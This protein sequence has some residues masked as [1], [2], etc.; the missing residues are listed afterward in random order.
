M[1]AIQD[2]SMIDPKTDRMLPVPLT[3]ARRLAPS[4]PDRYPSGSESDQ[5]RGSKEL[6]EVVAAVRTG[7]RFL[8][9]DALI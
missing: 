7:N 2:D 8:S 1:I 9:Y 4:A 5:Q 6:P 3:A